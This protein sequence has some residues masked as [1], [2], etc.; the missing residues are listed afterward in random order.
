VK[1]YGPPK[2]KRFQYV[3]NDVEAYCIIESIRH[4]FDSP[5]HVD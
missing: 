2:T 4:F 1:K 3:T 5:G